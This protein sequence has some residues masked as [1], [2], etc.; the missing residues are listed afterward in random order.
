MEG[1]SVVVGLDLTT[2][3]AAIGLHRLSD[4]IRALNAVERCVDRLWQRFP[5]APIWLLIVCLALAHLARFE[6]QWSLAAVAAVPTLPSAIPIVMFVGWIFTL[7]CYLSII[8][9]RVH[10]GWRDKAAGTL[11]IRN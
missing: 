8:W 2:L 4:R 9:D 1:W 5:P 6:I 7:L 3:G 11:V 10:Q